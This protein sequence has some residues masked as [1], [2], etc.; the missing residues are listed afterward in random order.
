[1]TVQ[2]RL[3]SWRN[4]GAIT[5]DQ[6]DALVALTHREPFSLFV[7]IN[8]L[9]YLG[10]M[11]FAGGVAWT[12]S[13]YSARFGDAAI[14][15]TLT[16]AFGATIYYCFSRGLAYDQHEVEQPAPAFDHVLYLGCLIFGVELE[17]LL[18][19]AAGL[20]DFMLIVGKAAA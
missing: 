7:E 9:L 8:A 5:G 13:T 16:A 20:F 1:M 12:I 19:G 11:S 18:E 10:V 14:L 4:A 15:A 17:H 2:A 3:E 6:H